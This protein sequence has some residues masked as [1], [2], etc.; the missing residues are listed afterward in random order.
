M[1]SGSGPDEVVTRGSPSVA[2]KDDL[3]RENV[4]SARQCKGE[5][6]GG[7]GDASCAN[8]YLAQLRTENPNPCDCAVRDAGKKGNGVFATQHIPEGTPVGEYVGEATRK[9][10]DTSEYVVRVGGTG[11]FVDGKVHG[12]WT[13]NVN[14]SC[15]PNCELHQTEYAGPGGAYV[16]ALVLVT[17]RPI[18]AGDELH[19]HYGNT[20]VRP[21]GQ[22]C[23]CCSV[24]C[25]DTAAHLC[26]LD[27]GKVVAAAAQLRCD[28]FAPKSNGFP[29]AA[30]VEVRPSSIMVGESSQL[31]NFAAAPIGA[32]VSCGKIEGVVVP[33]PD[34]E[35]QRAGHY[36]L[37]GQDDAGADMFLCIDAT[38]MS[39][40][41]NTSKDAS[42]VNCVA[43]SKFIVSRDRQSRGS[44]GGNAPVRGHVIVTSTKPI[45]RGAQLFLGYELDDVSNFLVPESVMRVV[46]HHNKHVDVS[47]CIEVKSC[48]ETRE[49]SDDRYSTYIESAA[50]CIT[51]Q[52]LALDSGAEGCV[53]KQL[54]TPNG[55]DKWEDVGEVSCLR[56]VE[57]ATLSLAARIA[58]AQIKGEDTTHMVQRGVLAREPVEQL[59]QRTRNVKCEDSLR[60]NTKGERNEGRAWCPREKTKQE[61]PEVSNYLGTAPNG[62]RALSKNLVRDT[63][64]KRTADHVTLQR[65]PRGLHL[66]PLELQ[67]M[68]GSSAFHA[69]CT[70]VRYNCSSCL[71]AA[72]STQ[73][74]LASARTAVYVRQQRIASGLHLRP[75]EPQF[76]SG[77]SAFHVGCT[78]VR[79]NCSSC[80]IHCASSA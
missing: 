23:C 48:E 29:K 76:M 42:Q 15:D 16:Y 66:R 12:N 68:P 73:D 58:A 46:E 4:H 65:F 53:E 18:S 6:Q 45:Q 79:Q 71:A 43:D 36:Y 75:L 19:F 55:P 47:H 9:K 7:A 54:W 78:C 37:R 20:W 2:A 10:S 34:L 32:G 17:S 33:G 31:G 5:C 59:S 49:E 50:S 52:K 62:F 25:E 41:I 39:N 61:Y 28:Y 27:V 26:E 77:S 11:V 56:E 8:K 22:R 38:C 74:A 64:A 72:H 13:R 30:L 1:A 44:T 40:F 3:H 69:G 67:F 14:H 24:L 57:E 21:E 51:K 80:S 60:N 35:K 63:L 70:C